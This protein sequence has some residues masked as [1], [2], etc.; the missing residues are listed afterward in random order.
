MPQDGIRDREDG[1]GESDA[2]REDDDDAE[3]ERW[4]AHECAPRE[5]N[6]VKDADQR[7]ARFCT[8][9]A[10][11]AMLTSR[12][13]EWMSEQSTPP[14]TTRFAFTARVAVGPPV[15]I[16]NGP[17]GLRRFVPILSGRVTGPRLT[18]RVV[19]GGGDWQLL[20][21]DGVLSL[22]A[23]YTVEAADGVLLAITN[24]GIRHGPPDVMAQLLAGK[25]V[26][27]ASSYFRTVARVEAPV[28]SAHEWMN[29][30]LFAGVGE[31][32]PETVTIHFF[33]VL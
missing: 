7:N 3:G 15:T 25:P 19:A 24:T 33:E 32:E 17:S 28:D 13:E 8:R 21:P 30:A 31:R 5:S 11:R 9:G 26:P 10:R 4:R 22:D 23:R 6:V 2:G 16:V 1:N 20:R 14:Y 12:C 29:R 27:A 18:G